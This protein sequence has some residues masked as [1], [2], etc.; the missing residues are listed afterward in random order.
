ME[1]YSTATSS[2][3][4]VR[5]GLVKAEQNSLFNWR[6]RKKGGPPPGWTHRFLALACTDDDHVPTTQAEKVLLEEAGLGEKV[7]DLDCGEEALRATMLSTFPKLQ[8]GRGCDA[9]QT[10]ES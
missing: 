5:E 8:E 1:A 3:R 10:Q 4:E 2:L 7:A 9:F 6:R